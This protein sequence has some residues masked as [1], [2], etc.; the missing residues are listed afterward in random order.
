MGLGDKIEGKIDKLKGIAKEKMGESADDPAVE[1][2]GEKDQVKGHAKEAWEEIK[3][4]AR[5]TRS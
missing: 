1:A 2:E 3:D 5:E 4:A